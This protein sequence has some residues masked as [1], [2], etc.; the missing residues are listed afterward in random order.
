MYF[1]GAG[2][3]VPGTIPGVVTVSATGPNDVLANYSNYGP[4]FIDIA[5]VGGDARLYDQYAAEGRFE[6]YALN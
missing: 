5:A 2:F 4:G 6:E 3:E 1:V